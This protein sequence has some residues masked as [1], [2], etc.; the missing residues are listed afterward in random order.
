MN[1]RATSSAMPPGTSDPL[2]S[3][4]PRKRDLPDMSGWDARVDTWEEVAATP[5]F[6]ELARLVVSLAAPQRDD[7]VVDLGAGTGLLSLIV[8]P[9]VETVVAVDA[10]P[11]M[12]ARLEQRAAAGGVTNVTPVLGDMRSLPLP[13]GSA[14]LVISNY[15]FHHLGPA[16]KEIALSEARR[17][18]V[19][20][21]RLVV[22]DMMFGLSL[23]ARDR[24][25]VTEKLKLIASVGP[26]GFARIA[27]NGVRILRG[28][29]EQPAPP[30]QW[31]RMLTARHFVDP[32]VVALEHE[33]GIATA[34][35]P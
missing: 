19:P 11:A 9:L 35:R 31:E 21:G 3:T 16:G 5:A 18:L 15:A 27:R 1:E 24:R 29:W 10:A 6:H 23:R 33:G 28:N 4:R 17:I 34:R 26:A 2:C 12:L 7:R 20:G 13:D 25:I 8:A 32:V 30:E 22:C 14:S